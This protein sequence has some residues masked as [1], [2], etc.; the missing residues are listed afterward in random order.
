MN[1]IY[2]E[3]NL[4]RAKASE[5]KEEI[6]EYRQMNLENS[7]TLLSLRIPNLRLREGE[8]TGFDVVATNHINGE[9]LGG[10]TLL[11]TG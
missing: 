9:V 8:M 4:G 2:N 11:V 6:K 5:F 1:K 7:M 3:I 10:I